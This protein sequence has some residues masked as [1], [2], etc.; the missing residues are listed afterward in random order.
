MLTP[1]ICSL[2]CS[3][4][5]SYIAIIQTAGFKKSVVLSWLHCEVIRS[6]WGINC[7][8]PQN[9]LRLPYHLNGSL[10]EYQGNLVFSLVESVSTEYK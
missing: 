7:W 4:A 6:V 2:F 8:L 5:V 1:S 9:W 10:L 3:I